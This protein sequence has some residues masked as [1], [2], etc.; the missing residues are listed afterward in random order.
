MEISVVIPVYNACHTIV[1]CLKSVVDQETRPLE[2]IVV[3]NGSTDGSW[4]LLEEFSQAAKGVPI[5]LCRERKRGASA[6]RNKGISLA[7]GEMVAFTDADCVA[8][9]GWLQKINNSFNHDSLGAVAGNIFGYRPLKTVEKF[10]SLYTLRGLDSERVFNHYTLI[11]GGFPTANLAVRK[12][13]LRA[14]GGFDE[15]FLIYGEDHDLCARI[16][17]KGF[18]IKYTPLAKVYH[19]HRNSVKKMLKQSYGFAKAH[20]R[21]MK[22]LFPRV[23]I[24]HFP[25][26]TLRG[27]RLPGRVWL[28]LTSADKKLILTVILGLLYSPLFLLTLFYLLYLYVST[29]KRG[30]SMG[31]NFSFR[32]TWAMVGLLLL[33]SLT[34]TGGR[35]IGSLRHRVIC[36]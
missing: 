19:R 9:V 30:L 34:M 11:E 25:G 33:K 12:E 27:E 7:R 36:F 13:V 6:A 8:D 28:N 3:D 23:Q 2:I 4:E 14:V 26:V 21:K 18:R 20:P 24:V 15:N 10:Q 35:L 17:K 5:V 29:F 1:D 31:F 32:E 16:Y 22:K